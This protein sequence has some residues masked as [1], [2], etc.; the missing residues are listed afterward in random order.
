MH[1]SG[2]NSPKIL[3]MSSGVLSIGTQKCSGVP[4]ASLPDAY[5]EC[6]PRAIP[7]LVTTMVYLS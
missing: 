5:H 2:P 6:L 4:S 7:S 3:I 1:M